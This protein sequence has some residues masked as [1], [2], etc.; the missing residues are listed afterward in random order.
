MRCKGC[1]WDSADCAVVEFSFGHHESSKSTLDRAFLN[2][3]RVLSRRTGSIDRWPVLAKVGG[4]H[5]NHC[6]SPA[7]ACHS[8]SPSQSIDRFAANENLDATANRAP[9]AQRKNE[10]PSQPRARDESGCRRSASCRPAF[11]LL[12]AWGPGLIK[13]TAGRKS[14]T[15]ICFADRSGGS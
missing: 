4:T 8:V 12:L 9:A 6:D 3:R 11:V 14:S 5:K 1:R 10:G 15:E 7:E 13:A 2:W